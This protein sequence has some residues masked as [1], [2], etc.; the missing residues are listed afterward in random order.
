[1]EK[2]ISLCISVCTLVAA[3]LAIIYI[4]PTVIEKTISERNSDGSTETDI[5]QTDTQTVTA[6]G[7]V[8]TDGTDTEPGIAPNDA[9]DD[10]DG[11]VQTDGTDT[12]PGIAPNDAA[13]DPDGTPQTADGR[14]P[15]SITLGTWTPAS[16]TELARTARKRRTVSEHI[17]FLSQQFLNTPYEANTLVGDAETP[18]QLTVNLAG[19]DCFTY[20]DYVESLRQSDSYPT[21]METLRTVRYRDGT[22]RFENRNHFF[23]DW[24]AHNTDN[25]T[26]VTRQIGGD[27]AVSVEKTLNVKKDGTHFLPGIP[28]VTRTVTHIPTGALDAATVAK[29]RTGDYIGVYT[30]IDGLDVTHTGIIIK[31]DGGTYLRHASSRRSVGNR[32][33]DDELLAYLDGKPGIVVYR[34]R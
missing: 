24:T 34:P 5:A 14:T 3:A 17:E 4:A 12:E 2:I 10:P 6:D 19:L 1:M 29:L 20:I 11:T 27:A 9:A 23:S 15:E 16:L 25:I 21:F 26:D 32:V 8:Q 28:A 13:D 22:V 33:V 31:K 7:T 30:N 18:E